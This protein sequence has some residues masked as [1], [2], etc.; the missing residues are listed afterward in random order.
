VKFWKT[1]VNPEKFCL[2]ITVYYCTDNIFSYYH[3]LNANPPSQG[4]QHYLRL[5]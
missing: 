1:G 2:V 5:N 3:F 4:W